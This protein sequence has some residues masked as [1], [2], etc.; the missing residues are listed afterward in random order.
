ML[1]SADGSTDGIAVFRYQEGEVYTPET[2]PP[3]TKYLAQIFLDAGQAEMVRVASDDAESVETAPE[4]GKRAKGP[5]ENK[6]AEGASETPEDAGSG[7]GADP[8]ISDLGTDD[9]A[10]G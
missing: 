7:G 3:M 9:G 5:S 10:E 2:N 8:A 4:K 1:V 6:A